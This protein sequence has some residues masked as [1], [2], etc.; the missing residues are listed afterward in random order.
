MGGIQPLP[1]QK[2][3]QLTGFA[4]RL[5]FPENPKLVGPRKSPPDRSLHPF[6]I[7]KRGKRPRKERLPR[8]WDYR[9]FP[10]SLVLFF[11]RLHNRYHL[12]LLHARFS[13][14]P[15]S[16]LLGRKCLTH[17]GTEG[18]GQLKVE[19]DWLQKKQLTLVLRKR[20]SA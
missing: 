4:A 18:I 3:S 1:P 14:P 6:G 10:S 16:K 15:Y 7:R 8:E 17:C 20:N 13:F 12:L 19:L 5:R 11:R 9:S 2:R